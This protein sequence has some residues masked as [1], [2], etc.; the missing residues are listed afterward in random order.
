MDSILLCDLKHPVQC[1]PDFALYID[2]DFSYQDFNNLTMSSM[3][4]IR[5]NFEGS[6]FYE[7]DL[8]ASTLLS[9]NLSGASFKKANLKLCNLETSRTKNATFYESIFDENTQFPFSMEEA[10]SKKMVYHPSLLRSL[11]DMNPMES[12]SK[13]FV[14]GGAEHI[15][16]LHSVRQSFI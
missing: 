7:T 6:T 1:P 15:K 14:K 5:C 2:L 12:L 4:F 3:R 13:I 8:Q 10:L 16:Q 11:Q 9:C